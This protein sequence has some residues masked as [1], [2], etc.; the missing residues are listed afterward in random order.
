MPD[1]DSR[2]LDFFLAGDSGVAEI[3]TLEISQPSFSQ[4]WRLQCHYRKGLTTKLES[5]QE[6][7]WIYLPMRLRPLEERGNLDFG[8]SVT[9]GDTGDIL[10]DEIQ[11]AREAGTLRASPPRVVYRI[12][13]SDDLDHPMYGPITLEAREIGRTREGA[14]FN[15]LA[16][17]LNVSKTGEQYSTDRFEGL[18]G[19]L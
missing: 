15:A 17:E 10:P 4:V 16:P 14:Q 7:D 3:H 9:L 1:V 18:L 12:Y 5:G 19:L 8:L 2:Y 11:R 6:V 13:R